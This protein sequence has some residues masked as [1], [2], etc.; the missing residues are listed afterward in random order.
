[1]IY[2]LVYLFIETLVSVEISSQIGGLNTFLEMILTAG[3]GIYILRNFKQSL[4]FNVTE[5][6]GGGISLNQFKSRNIFPFVG[7]ILL[8]V[9]GFFSDILGLILQ[10]SIFT[11]LITSSEDDVQLK[12]DIRRDDFEEKYRGEDNI[13]DIDVIDSSD[14]NRDRK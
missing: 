6:M 4:F 8:I 11:D 14:S 10:F 5:F 7:A 13:I 9:P 12:T 2:I 1:M 3:I